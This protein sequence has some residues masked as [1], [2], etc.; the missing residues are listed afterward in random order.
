[1]VLIDDQIV[2]S[3][4]PSEFLSR[5]RPQNPGPSRRCPFVSPL[6]E[7]LHWRATRDPKA[8]MLSLQSFLREG[9]V[10]GLCWANYN[11]KDLKAFPCRLL[12]H[13]N[14]S[15]AATHASPPLHPLANKNPPLSPP[16]LPSPNRADPVDL[17]TR[18]A[19]RAPPHQSTTRR[20]Q[21]CHGGQR[22]CQEAGRDCG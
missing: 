17:D 11:L 6:H 5:S 18:K 1:M 4:A 2:A 14:R 3:S 21:N 20:V 22:P 12:L 15:M 10:V 16:C 7:P 13:K 19:D 9:R 8:F